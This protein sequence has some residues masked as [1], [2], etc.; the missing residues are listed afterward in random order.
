MSKAGNHFHRRS[1][2]SAS[3]RRW[4]SNVMKK[5][6]V[7]RYFW[8]LGFIVHMFAPAQLLRAEDDK[9]D[10]ALG[11]ISPSSYVAASCKNP[12]EFTA[13]AP[14]TCC[15]RTPLVYAVSN[16]VFTANFDAKT[17]KSVPV[18]LTGVCGHTHH[19]GPAH[20]NVRIIYPCQ[21]CTD[22]GQGCADTGS[23]DFHVSLGSTAGGRFGGRLFLYA[24]TVPDDS[25][26]SPL[27]LQVEGEDLGVVQVLRPIISA[28]TGG[29]IIEE[30]DGK[31]VY[32][33]E[34]V[35]CGPIRQIRSSECLVKVDTVDKYGYALSFFSTQNVETEYDEEGYYQPNTPTPHVVYTLEN[36]D[37]E[38]ACERLRITEKR[39]GVDPVVK[40]FWWHTNAVGEVSWTLVEGNG[41]RTRVLTEDENSKTWTTFGLDGSTNSVV[42]RVYAQFGDQ[43]LPTQVVIDPDGLALTTHALYYTDEEDALRF[44]RV[45]RKSNPT[46]RGLSTTIP[47]TVTL[48]ASNAVCLMTFPT[49][50]PRMIT[51]RF[52]KR[53]ILP[54]ACLLTTALSNPAPRAWKPCLPAIAFLCPRPCAPWPWTT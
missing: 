44:G 46:V 32:Y 23:L 28:G 36:P 47:T 2:C 8:V 7:F 17:P 1:R 16:V 38:A 50:P 37:R 26:F 30:K 54:P 3:A 51:R 45:Q 29:E 12:Q 43:K 40:E 19:V 27:A 25:L 52:W 48:R 34:A 5:F 31:T 24:D 9:C 39:P 53:Q 41:L 35:T 14:I 6:L 10:A 20:G 15:D 13:S 42:R 21:D 18:S 49:T 4:K 22:A 33:G 11:K